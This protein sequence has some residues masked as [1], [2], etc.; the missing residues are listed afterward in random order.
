[1]SVIAAGRPGGARPAAPP[2]SAFAWRDLDALFAESDV[3]S[4]HCPLT[5]E[6]KDMV[7]GERL[8]RMRPTAYL[9]N[10]ARG[11]LVDE[12]AL[13]EALR[14]GRIAGAALDV[15]SQEPVLP[16]NPLLG[17]PRCILTPHLAWASLSARQRLMSTS[18]ENVRAFLAGHPI[19]VV[20]A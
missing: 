19:H 15:V 10:T 14:H 11:G 12:K 20:S 3:V 6:S 9:I 7:N 2:W 1:M 8:A 18:V 16:T 4:L 17:A 13:A 5:P